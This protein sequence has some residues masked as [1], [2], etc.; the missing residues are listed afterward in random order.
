MPISK[1]AFAKYFFEVYDGLAGRISEQEIGLEP[2]YLQILAL[3]S[4]HVFLREGVDAA[5]YETHNGGE[6][7]ATNVIDR[8]LVTAVT[9]I[10]MDHVHQLGPSVGN[11]AW[12]KAGIFKRGSPAFSAPQSSSIAKVLR[13]RAAEKEVTLKFVD[14]DSDLPKDAPQLEPE[15]QRTNCSLAR[16]ISNAFLRQ[17]GRTECGVLTWQDVM[18]GVRQFHWKGRFHLIRDGDSTWFLDGAH[19][20]LSIRKAADWFVRTASKM[21]R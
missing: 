4:F 2:R 13:S 16:A 15:V 17:K 1:P 8:P 10:D 6:Y 21:T 3:L 5:I 9:S 7:D 19:N 20:E 11:I 12:H 18:E 14:I